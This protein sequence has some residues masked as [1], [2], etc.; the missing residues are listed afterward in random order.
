MHQ[1]G[2]N[3]RMTVAIALLAMILMRIVWMQLRNYHSVQGRKM[4]VASLLIGA[5]GGQ[6][7][8]YSLTNTSPERR[9]LALLSSP[10]NLW[11]AHWLCENNLPFD[12]DSLKINQGLL[13]FTVLMATLMTRFLTSSWTVSLIVAATLMSR[14]R[15]LADLG[16]FSSDWWSLMA[17]TGWFMGMS[18]YLRTGSRLAAAWAMML[19]AVGAAFEPALVAAGLALPVLLLMGFL[20]RRQLARPVMLRLRA[21]NR[22]LRELYRQSRLIPDI[23][24][25]GLVGRLAHGLR[26][27]GWDFFGQLPSEPFVPSYGRGNLLRTLAV[28]FLLWAYHRQRWLRISLGWLCA[29]VTVAALPFLLGWW[30]YPNWQ[31][32][33]YAAQH[34]LGGYAGSLWEFAERT[35]LAQAER[36]DLHLGLSLLVLLISACQSPARGLNGFLEATWLV[37]AAL[38]LIG[39]A[40]LGFEAID[41]GVIDDLGLS[42]LRFLFPHL[43]EPRALLLWFEPVLLSLGICSAYNLIKVFDSWVADKA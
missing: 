22:K 31:P 43:A 28:P 14:G 19:L 27:V 15:L 26:R 9:S 37:L 30:I 41:L 2:L 17:I 33:T 36:I 13:L 20:L 16:R 40:V 5:S 42:D 24:V 8:S 10:G 38:L 11:L 25:E 23:E 1:R 7:C 34:A 3:L 21:V 35:L 18:H 6:P 32:L 4:A 12:R 29:T 39:I